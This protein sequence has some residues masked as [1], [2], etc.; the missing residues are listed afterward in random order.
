[1]REVNILTKNDNIIRNVA[2]LVPVQF[3]E[4]V[5]HKI[6]DNLT[7]AQY[8]FMALKRGKSQWALSHGLACP[9]DTKNAIKRIESLPTYSN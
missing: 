7:D 6:F 1:M 9:A 2:E 8:L 5:D 3:D 4:L